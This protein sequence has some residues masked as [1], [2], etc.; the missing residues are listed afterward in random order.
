M[1][2]ATLHSVPLGADAAY[3]TL[4]A[5]GP[6]P[7]AR[8]ATAAYRQLAEALAREGMDIVHE[9]T[10]CSLDV[11]ERVLAGRAGAMEDVGRAPV[12][13]I[14][15]RPAWGSGFSGASV[16]AARGPVELLRDERGRPLGRSWRADGAKFTLLQSLHGRSRRP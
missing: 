13:C 15:G 14:Q 3:F 16:M 5:R 7:A 10:F 2:A 11:C 4:V 1:G 8:A 6:A 9:R 12:T